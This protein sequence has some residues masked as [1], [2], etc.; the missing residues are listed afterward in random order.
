MG[1]KRFV[2]ATT[3]DAMTQVR[4]AL[5]DD[6]VI[7]S[8]KRI[9]GGS[10]EILAAAADAVEQIVEDARP[11]ANGRAQPARAPQPG[12]QI[13][14]GVR[15]I[16]PPVQ[17]FQ[18]FL[19]R[20][21]GAPTA[22][23]A[24]ATRS[25][26]GASMYRAVA[27]EPL[28]SDE[29]DGGWANSRFDPSLMAGTRAPTAAPHP[30][31]TAPS[32]STASALR[33]EAPQID[34]W[35]PNE[36]RGEGR[37]EVSQD[38]RQDMRQDLRHGPRLDARNDPRLASLNGSAP[39]AAAVPAPRREFAP[40]EAPR[41]QPM[42]G[43]A[44]PAVFRR[45]PSREGAPQPATI[46]PHVHPMP[47]LAQPPVQPM[48]PPLQ[49][50]APQPASQALVPPVM[51]PAVQPMVQ[52]IAAAP[53]P[54]PAPSQP[55]GASIDLPVPAA[56]LG[57]AMP[58]QTPAQVAMPSPLAAAPIAPN[59]PM[60]AIAPAQAAQPASATPIAAPLQST[61]P[62]PPAAQAEP[63]ALPAVAPA[64][65]PRTEIRLPGQ[66]AGQ[67]AS[68]QLMAELV[69][70]R[71]SLQQQLA[72]LSNT[73]AATDSMRRNPLQT[74]VMTRLLTS[75]FSVDV[76]RKI[77]LNTPVLENNEAADAWMQDVL[78]H[79][80]RAA[81]ADENL[82]DR[83]GVIAL[84]GPTGVGKTT[85]VAKL[86]ARFAVKYG[87]AGLGLVTLDAYRVAAHEQLRTYG[88]ILGTPV[89][90]AQDGATLREL[91][92]SMQNK[93]LVLIDTCGVGPRDERLAEILSTLAQAGSGARKVKPVLLLNAA[94]HAETLDEIARA[95]RA[96]E[97]A[98]T[99]LTKLDEAARIG[100]AL[101][102]ALRHKLKLLALTNGQRVPEDLHQPNVRL[103]AHLALKPSSEVFALAD[104]EGAA[105]AHLTV[106]RAG[107]LHA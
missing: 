67:A 2:A 29:D 47:P 50:Q 17:S 14:P 35:L 96:P 102:C 103:L 27:A 58:V 99:I 45:R 101:D 62:L 3:K 43:V 30:R 37:H 55:I 81:G 39:R 106:T 10:I 32:R 23:S 93:R 57:T 25:A 92:A 1:F 16:G 77:A 107:A 74:R 20:Q 41:P 54:P 34:T 4:R 98:G 60:A 19:K 71:A 53:L 5:G 97:A 95:W 8:N 89:H 22:A 86:A 76:A 72:S 63:V 51:R 28:A 7:L 13:A 44:E 33:A 36:A 18:D 78:A 82:V 75:G 61:A 48:Q 11:P 40:T 66:D 49:Q 42:H 84:V 85:T 83:G 38:M 68:A 46:T 26:G 65:V 52:P 12:V 24:P 80:L 90:M 15:R 59:A 64:A 31:T 56:A 9:A 70:L 104:D 100:G 73:V 88:R 87:S 91:L 94:S 79:N 69:S 105:L 6:A 21:G